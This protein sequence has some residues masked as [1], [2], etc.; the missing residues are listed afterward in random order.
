MAACDE[1]IP[2]CLNV[3]NRL[4]MK[5]LVNEDISRD[6]NT[7]SSRDVSRNFKTGGRSRGAIDF[8]RSGYYF[9][10]PSHIPY[11]FVVRVENKIHIVT[12][13]MLTTIKVYAC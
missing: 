13:S 5:H 6:L 7:A 9:D 12:C 2:K 10:T 1:G 4:S 8:M 11:L 3:L